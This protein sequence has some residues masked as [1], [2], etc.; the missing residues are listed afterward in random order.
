MPDRSKD[1]DN[2]SAARTWL[3]PPPWRI[4]LRL[5]IAV[6]GALLYHGVL[7]VY[8]TYRNTYD[9]YVH[10]FFA[11]HW[12]R[13][14]FD[15]W[16]PRWYTGFTL[17][18]YPPL[19]QQ[20]VAALSFL[21]GDLRLAFAIVQASA[22]VV[23]TIG[24]YRFA[25]LWVSREAAGWAAIWLVLS[26]AMAETI[27]VFGQLPTTYSLA[28]LLNALPYT[29]AWIIRG[30]SADLIKCWALVAA[31]TGAHHVTTLFGSVFITAPVLLLALFERLNTAQP[32][33]PVRPPRFI[34]RTIWRAVSMLHL[35]RVLGP[36][37]RTGLFGVGTIG[38]LLLVVFPYWAWSRSDPISQVPIP[39]A[40]RDNFLVNLNAGLVFWLIPYGMLLFAMPY[41]FYKGFTTKAWPLTSSIALLAF[42]GTGGTTPFPKLLLGGAFDILTLDRFTLWASILMLPLAGEYMVSLLH[43]NLA[44]WLLTQFGLLV[45]RG[46]IVFTVV[47]LVL[48]SIFV[49][50]LTQFRRFQPAPI[51]MQPI[52][53]FLA[54]DDHWRWRYLTLGFG[55]Q[56]AWLSA[57]TTAPQID[58]N[59]HSARRLPEMTTTPVERL[60]GAK[61]SGVPGL[62]SLQ[63]F[64]N[65]PD[66]Y[67]LKYVFS[68]DQ[69]YDPLLF[70]YGWHKIQ[71]L[72]NG[73]AVWERADIP[74]L[75]E[76]LPR[77]EIPRYQRL[78][79]GILPPGALLFAMLAV[80]APYWQIP[81]L[82]LGEALGL[83]AQAGHRYDRLARP[84]RRLWQLLDRW[85]WAASA[86]PSPLR[87]RPPRWQLLIHLWRRRVRRWSKPP[88]PSARRVRTA[89]LL[90]GITL[91]L[92]FGGLRIASDWRDPLTLVTSYYDNLDFQRFAAAYEQLNPATRP[93]LAQY[94]LNLSV[95]GGLVASYS[96]LDN[97]T[98]TILQADA[99]QMQVQVAARYLTALSYYTNTQTLHLTNHPEEGWRIEPTASDLR[100]PPGQ[101]LR[102]PTLDWLTI[103]G[104]PPAPQ[105][106][107]FK[108]I[109]DRPALQILSARLVQRAQG[110]YSVVGEL[111]NTD[112]DPADATVTGY[113]YDDQ[114][115]LLTWYNAGAAMMHKLF[116]LEITPFR[117]DF[118]GVAGLALQG[119]QPPLAF[120]PNAAWDYEPPVGTQLGGFSVLAKAV[121]AQQDLARAVGAQ[122]L[123]VEKTATGYLLSGALINAGLQEAVIPHLLVTFYDAAGDVQWVDHFFL[124]QSLR[125]QRTMPFA[126]PL[127]PRQAVTTVAIPGSLYADA[128]TPIP[129]W[130]LPRAD[131]L[132][133]P[134]A[135]GYAYLRVSVH[136]FAGGS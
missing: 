33:E 108:E 5:L 101:F 65:V 115:T 124:P 92:T 32:D 34:T 89:V 122:D 86:L 104:R 136:Y 118:E 43:G 94:M 54:K 70:F 76:A 121:V 18:S 131:W 102:Q 1:E 37:L 130:P 68:N 25:Q 14:W 100:V 41:I 11:D 81:L 24:M 135:A 109:L 35:R 3:S 22:M 114:G 111:F 79:F 98:T 126:L 66:K 53:T 84:W 120:T 82:F 123:H 132:A 21:T 55:D 16:D 97:L 72:E 103:G 91:L 50:N 59:Y 26:S 80:S 129:D 88:S 95:Q 127:T 40:S 71:L 44:R 47:G 60:E 46:L 113:I 110:G 83:R 117:I 30:R 63:Q 19:S 7:S 133:L 116:P 93:T 96:K 39:H 4:D 56:M 73:I 28:L 42:L 105:I 62:G 78:M 112:T 58:G 85:L 64:L 13:G 52:V 12:T 51:D 69:F 9:A 61:F 15:H 2:P 128:V 17:T 29:Y 134:S 74:I 27:H 36:V 57:Q 23:M 77:K 75:P 48:C 45:Q 20:S 49:V 10:I 31:T 125:A 99:E 90:L 119:T 38:L 107:D 106:V 8:G 87:Y 6:L 67:N